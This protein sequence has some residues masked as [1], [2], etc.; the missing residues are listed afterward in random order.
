MQYAGIFYSTNNQVANII[1]N[2]PRNMNA[3]DYL[4]AEEILSAL[5]EAEADQ[6]VKVIILTASGK[7]FCAGGDISEMMDVIDSDYYAK[8]ATA[9]AL[10]KIV[11]FIKK[12]SKP[13]ISSVFGAVAGAGFTL[14]VACDFCIATDDTRFLPVFAN[15]ALVPDAGGLYILSRA[16]GAKRA[17]RMA[18]DCQPVTAVQGLEWGFVYKTCSRDQLIK[19]AEELALKLV[20]GPGLSYKYMKELIYEADY[21]NFEYYLKLEERRQVDCISSEDHLEGIR[22]FCEKR[23]PVFKGK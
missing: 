10:C 23:T 9:K 7:H 18:M 13:V 22:A 4:M 14:A 6:N 20:K 12:M 1:L 11:L 8:A 3:I 17:V 16:V 5:K 21:S 2:S 15:M 19:E